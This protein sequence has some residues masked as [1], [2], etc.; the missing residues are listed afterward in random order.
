MGRSTKVS[1]LLRVLYSVF[2][3]KNVMLAGR[4]MSVL[5]GQADAPPPPAPLRPYNRSAGTSTNAS[6]HTNKHA[7][8]EKKPP[9][10]QRPRHRK[11]RQVPA[12]ARAKENTTDSHGTIF[13]SV[14][15]AS[16]SSAPGHG[17][18]WGARSSLQFSPAQVFGH[19]FV[20]R[21]TE[22][23][24]KLEKYSVLHKRQKAQI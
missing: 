2:V 8:A 1:L 6:R 5:P 10:R 3:V 17:L 16:T 12:A 20:F 15:H 23:A 13:M 14:S 24:T 4:K 9:T 18:R 11:P 21:S 19:F 7:E 22:S